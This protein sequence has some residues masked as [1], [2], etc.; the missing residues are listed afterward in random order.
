MNLKLIA[1][2]IPCNDFVVK[3]LQH[4]VSKVYNNKDL[5]LINVMK[6]LLVVYFLFLGILE[7]VN[8]K[9]NTRIYSSDLSS[10]SK[11]LQ[12]KRT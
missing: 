9:S 11:Q 7:V 6:F 12:F 8:F 5:F 4:I 3:I 1:N 2:E 10:Q